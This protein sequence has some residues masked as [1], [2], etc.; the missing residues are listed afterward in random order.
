MFQWQHAEPSGG[1]RGFDYSQPPTAFFRGLTLYLRRHYTSNAFTPALFDAMGETTGE[2]V[3]SM[4]EDWLMTPGFPQ[5]S[6]E[7]RESS[8]EV[9][10]TQ[11]PFNR[12]APASTRW[13]IPVSYITRDSPHH[14]RFVVLN[15]TQP[16]AIQWSP[17]DNLDWIKLNVNGSAFIRVSYTQDL[18]I[19][20]A[21]AMKTGSLNKVDVATLEYDAPL[22]RPMAAAAAAGPTATAQINTSAVLSRTAADYLSFNIDAAELGTGTYAPFPWSSPSL[23]KL[24]AHLAP[25]KLRVG[26]GAQS[27]TVYNAAMLKQIGEIVAFKAAANVSLVWGTA[28]CDA[29][30]CDMANAKALLDSE[31][32]AAI[33]EWEYGNEPGPQ[34]D[35]A[36]L[37]RQFVAFS[38]LLQA[39][40]PGK[41]LVGADVGYGAWADPPLPGTAD[42]AWLQTFYA[43]AGGV[44]A[45]AT[46]HVYPF[47]HNDVGGDAHAMEDQQPHANGM[48][49]TLQDPACA[50]EG[51]AGRPSMPWCNYSRVIWP[52]PAELFDTRP[53]QDFA[54]NFA[55]IVRQNSTGGGGDSAAASLRIGETAAVNHGGWANVTN[56]FVSGFWSVYQ[57]GWLAQAGYQVMHRQSLACRGGDSGMGHGER[58]TYGLLTN[59]TAAGVFAP[60]P[61][62]WTTL[63]YKRLMGRSILNCS[64]SRA[65][66]MVWARDGIVPKEQAGTIRLFAACAKSGDAGGAVA[67]MYANPQGVAV[68]LVLPVADNLGGSTRELYVLS[69]A[70]DGTRNPPLQSSQIAL[71]G[72]TLSMVGADKTG[73]PPLAGKA[74]AGGATSPLLLPPRTYGFVVLAEAKASACMQTHRHALKADDGEAEA[75]NAEQAAMLDLRGQAGRRL[76]LAQVN[77]ALFDDEECQRRVGTRG[78][79]TQSLCEPLSDDTAVLYRYDRSSRQA[80]RRF[81]YDSISCA[82]GSPSRSSAMSF[83]RCTPTEGGRSEQLAE[84]AVTLNNSDSDFNRAGSP[85]KSSAL[86]SD[87]DSDKSAESIEIPAA[88]RSANDYTIDVVDRAPGPGGGS[89]ISY[90]NGTS[91][92]LFNYNAAYFASNKAGD[93]D[94]LIVRVQARPKWFEN[95][96][97]I[98]FPRSGLAAVRRIGGKGSVKFEH[99]SMDNVFVS[100]PKLDCA[101]SLSKDCAPTKERPCAD[102]PRIMY[103]AKTDTYYLVYDNDLNGR[104]SM[105]ATSKTPWNVS[106]WT[107]YDSPIFADH[108]TT[109]GASLLARDDYAPAPDLHYAFVAIAGDAGPM[110]VGTSGDLIHWNV[111]DTIWQQGRKGC[112]D[113]NG[114]AAGP[115]A[116]R[117]SDGNYLLLYNID[118]NKNCQSASCGK[119][120]LDCSS[121]GLPSACSQ[122]RCLDG[123]C[124]VGWM[125]LDQHDPSKVLAR[126]EQ[127]LLFAQLLPE[128]VGNATAK[129]LPCTNGDCHPQGLYGCTQTPWVVFSNGL[130]KLP[131]KDEFV[132]WFGAGDTNVGAASIRVNIPA[133]TSLKTDDEFQTVTF[134]QRCE[135]A[136]RNH[137]DKPWP[138][139]DNVP[140]LEQTSP[141]AVANFALARLALDGRSNA[142]LAAEISAEVVTYRMRFRPWSNYSVKG[143]M[144]GLGQLPVLQRMALLPLTRDLLTSDALAALEQIS[145]EWL[146]PRSNVEW[147]GADDS[148]TITDGSENLDATRKASLY[149]AALIV[150]RTTPDKIVALDG[151]PVREHAAAW[152]R[153]YRLYFQHRAV[154]GLGVEMGSP[155]YAKY[156]I[157]NFLNIADLSP[158]VGALASDFL[159]LWFAHAAQAF[160]PSTGVRGGAH[161]RVYRDSAF[162]SGHG[163]AETSLGWLYGWWHS[164]K[165]GRVTEA[166][167]DDALGL[168]QMTLFATSKWQ[169]LPIISAMAVLQPTE[170]FVYTSRRMGDNKPCS[171]P[172][173]PTCKP[174]RVCAGVQAFGGSACDSLA[175]PSTVIKE[176]Y[177]A[178]KRLFTLGAISLNVS[179]PE[180]KHWRTDE[181]MYGADVGQNHQI[182]AF[183]GG[184]NEISSRIVF[185][186]SGSVNCSDPAFQRH[187]FMGITSRLVAGAVAIARP[188]SGKINGCNYCKNASA[189]GSE[190]GKAPCDT[191]A[192]CQNTDFPLFAFVSSDLFNTKKRA[193]AWW[194]FDAGE[195]Y[196]CV[197]LAGGAELTTSERCSGPGTSPPK[198]DRSPAFFNGTLLL[199]NT[200][201]LSRSIGVLQTGSQATDGSFDSFISKM[202]AHPIPTDD[203]GALRYTA[204]SGELLRMG[205]GGVILPA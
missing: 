87:D 2:P 190:S 137:V 26:G 148:W 112:F 202:T 140:L 156:S 171:E 126:S 136:L 70:P 94:G 101:D 175:F 158:N 153:H 114:L 73:L 4:L 118:N 195:S 12:S 138:K 22:V 164:T 151:K 38:K 43:A 68:A 125:I 141:W 80:L 204:L 39:A 135:R 56:A 16:A 32:G 203:D 45:G 183:F 40:H 157:Q 85:L 64:A 113:H 124:S 71:N 34:G 201:K 57:I 134:E 146:S 93:A 116:E 174:C 161:N 52:G 84:D 86:K 179:S 48:G 133:A 106:S 63:L 62:Y 65:A 189:L 186:D 185:G 176:E 145:F 184:K 123:R 28:P 197:G 162:F 132:V 58:C 14:A 122:S 7:L 76:Q 33:D 19:R 29:K 99:V 18:W 89:V 154:N 37:A 10:L 5:V 180:D 144:G 75:K 110:Y 165:D 188:A 79:F 72:A 27:H 119:C 30:H 177:V 15:G 108:P 46:V 77:V 97:E 53:V 149:L 23:A 67:L 50:S 178:P 191:R 170:G 127:P 82:D 24:T 166:D 131:G 35:A 200:S 182:G 130:Q 95:G 83:T 61:D 100:C 160:I 59:P 91:D 199:F 109:S 96:T 78:P 105:M 81:H 54:L 104:V 152:E 169:P 88:C 51:A 8:Q 69:A 121:S 103:R 31:Q 6:A 129:C 17:E 49:S 66:P 155:T 102:D 193:G 205:V 143:P 107:F 20:L 3:G 74:Q 92:F 90:S 150:N 194:Y 198:N 111:S 172:L 173:G 44:L 60:T 41:P 128:T 163:S 98:H 117:L 1:C 25:A 42:E 11:Q 159:Q 36:E 187:S 139:L 21:A 55:R 9:V 168:P 181:P 147:A 192:S 120:G 167:V 13:W 115:P 47:D 196:G 142:S